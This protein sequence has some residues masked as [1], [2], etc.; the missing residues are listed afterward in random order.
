MHKP[1][2]KR[3]SVIEMLE[4]GGLTEDNVREISR[5]TDIPEADIWGTGSFYHLIDNEQQIAAGPQT[6]VCN[7]LT[8]RMRGADELADRL[9]SQGRHVTRISC[10]GQCDLAPALLNEQSELETFAS[11]Q[12]AVT[13]D[14]PALPL[15]L[16][17]AVDDSYRNLAKAKQMSA[18]QIIEQL[19][20]SGFCKPDAFSLSLIHI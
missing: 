20:A 6:R 17:G 14:N 9:T 5:Q 12:T 13:P 3:E 1:S 4:H 7:G 16:G 2:A 10:L 19:K 11:I 15:N 8:C 18:K